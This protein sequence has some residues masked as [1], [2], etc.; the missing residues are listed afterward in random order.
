MSAYS[1]DW[2]TTYWQEALTR[3]GVRR[4]ELPE[5]TDEQDS[6]CADAASDR[7]HS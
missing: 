1:E 2:Y 5:L 7:W 3:Y 6:N 4:G